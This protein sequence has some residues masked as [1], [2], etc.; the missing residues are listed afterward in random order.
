MCFIYSVFFSVFGGLVV[1]ATLY[2][3]FLCED[4]SKHIDFST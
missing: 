2:D 1:L 4:Q 3:Y